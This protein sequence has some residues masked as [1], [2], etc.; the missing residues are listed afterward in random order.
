[1]SKIM[2]SQNSQLLSCSVVFCIHTVTLI[3]APWLLPYF[4]F[5]WVCL[6][7]VN[8]SVKDKC[9]NSKTS[10]PPLGTYSIPAHKDTHGSTQS[11]SWFWDLKKLLIRVNGIWNPRFGSHGVPFDEQLKWNIKLF[12]IQL[13][14]SDVQQAAGLLYCVWTYALLHTDVVLKFLIIWI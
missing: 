12:L 4:S 14:W 9:Q 6:C 8:Y 13:H 2:S 10:P 1:M 5:T 3:T 7:N 11:L